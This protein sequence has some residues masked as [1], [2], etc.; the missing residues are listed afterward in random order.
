MSADISSL[1]SATILIFL[2]IVTDVDAWFGPVI[3]VGLHYACS[4]LIRLVIRDNLMM[5]ISSPV[6]P[7]YPAQLDPYHC[8][9]A[10]NHMGVIH[11]I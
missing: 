9:L 4:N 7:V 10:N 6:Y 8:A 2:A 1:P 11:P 3:I 5:S